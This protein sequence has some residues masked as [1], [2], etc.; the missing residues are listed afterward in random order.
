[1]ATNVSSCRDF[2]MDNIIDFK[3]QIN[4]GTPLG[5]E[6][7]TTTS[8]KAGECKAKCINDP[9]CGMWAVSGNNCNKYKID[10]AFTNK[11]DGLL[12]HPVKMYNSGFPNTPYDVS[13]QENK[14]ACRTKC[15]QDPDCNLFEF[16]SSDQTCTLSK[17]S[18][19]G[20]T[21]YVRSTL[22]IGFDCLKGKEFYIIVNQNY[23]V[24][25]FHA[26]ASTLSY[27]NGNAPAG[28]NRCLNDVSYNVSAGDKMR[29]GYT[30]SLIPSIY[31]NFSTS[32]FL[33]LTS[34]GKTFQEI[35]VYNSETELTVQGY[36]QENRSGVSLIGSCSPTC[37]LADCVKG[38]E[39]YYLD[40][41]I[42]VVYRFHP[43]NLTLSYFN[44][45]GRNVPAG[46][47][48][49]DYTY[50]VS[51]DK[52]QIEF[53]YSSTYKIIL[54]NFQSTTFDEYDQRFQYFYPD[55]PNRWDFTRFLFNPDYP[56]LTMRPSCSPT[57]SAVI[58]QTP[59]PPPTTQ[60]I[61]CPDIFECVKGKEYVLE[62]S[63]LSA[64]P[65][66]I[67]I[68]FFNDDKTQLLLSLGGQ[69]C[70]LVPFDILFNTIN[71]KYKGKNSFIANFRLSNAVPDTSVDLN[72]V[73]GIIN[74]T[75][76]GNY[77]LPIN[78]GSAFPVGACT[79]ISACPS[80]NQI[81]Y[82]EDGSDPSKLFCADGTKPQCFDMCSDPSSVCPSP[83]TN[84]L[85]FMNDDDYSDRIEV[86]STYINILGVQYRYFVLKT[87][88]A[89]VF[90]FI[91]Y[92]D[93]FL[94]KKDTIGTPSVTYHRLISLRTNYSYTELSMYF[95]K[96]TII[97]PV[98]D[99]YKS[100]SPI[101]S[102][103]GEPPIDKE[104]IL[105]HCY[106]FDHPQ[107]CKYFPMTKSK[108]NTVHGI[109][110]VSPDLTINE[111]DMV[112]YEHLLCPYEDISVTSDFIESSWFVDTEAEKMNIFFTPINKNVIEELQTFE[113]NVYHDY[114]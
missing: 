4:L 77:T 114:F 67:I 99:S 73:R 20:P 98:S 72:I 96:R 65:G 76:I 45:L 70:I 37:V 75:L 11:F 29:L 19:P 58:A 59:V 103:C 95:Y 93:T 69:N 101:A 110:E 66:R 102:S 112:S 107:R 84:L 24:Y 10:A 30:N 7:L 61:Q 87:D 18:S 31:K 83:I 91:T 16:D 2:E 43:T 52:S 92:V 50:T 46:T 3:G 9:T 25:K 89:N 64:Y 32:V 38:R 42:R 111:E 23:I 47:L 105:Y 35:G 88:Y 68:K 109:D 17:C 44:S 34:D 1:M 12:V 28:V 39:Y 26:T 85:K 90:Q 108:V 104:E 56:G 8:D 74:G 13:V 80:T 106:M 63:P 33:Q 82:C 49:S 41:N 51:A 27:F 79:N 55:D 6:A 40:N 15:K 60:V 48:C 5:T 113:I 22:C 78:T 62:T 86:S 57:S 14:D 100:I 53:K 97:A 54:K 81:Q 21:G 36:F 94:Y 71:F